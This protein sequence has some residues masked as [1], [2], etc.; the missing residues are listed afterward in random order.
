MD[1][2][3]R[4]ASTPPEIRRNIWA[5]LAATVEAQYMDPDEGLGEYLAKFID[6]PAMAY[7]NKYRPDVS[8]DYLKHVLSARH[9]M[10]ASPDYGNEYL[11]QLFRD[12]EVLFHVRFWQNTFE[13]LRPVMAAL[14]AWKMYW[15]SRG[16]I[17]A[18]PV[19]GFIIIDVD[20]QFDE[21]GEDELQVFRCATKELC[22]VMTEF[23][24]G[25]F[26]AV[27]YVLSDEFSKVYYRLA[28][29]GQM[30]VDGD[31]AIQALD[32]QFKAKVAADKDHGL[33][34][35]VFDQDEGDDQ[36]QRTRRDDAWAETIE[37]LKGY[38]ELICGEVEKFQAAKRVSSNKT[39]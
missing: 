20:T 5:Y 38:T 8:H 17:D 13:D 12:H 35:I 4:I 22:Q 32:R 28:D 23:P 9:I 7:L 2:S 30:R 18:M 3:E 26:L 31:K 27:S 34:D 14:I 15:E 10:T 24:Q 39:D 11:E 33:L 37:S 19:T 1:L 36:F 6:S 21:C 25:L 16:Q 29:H